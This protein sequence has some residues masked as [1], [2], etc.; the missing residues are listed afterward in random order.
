MLFFWFL[1][2]SFS[3]FTIGSRILAMMSSRSLA[4]FKVIEPLLVELIKRGHDVTFI[5]NYPLGNGITNYTLFDTRYCESRP[6]SVTPFA[7]LHSNSFAYGSMTWMYGY[8]CT[9]DCILKSEQFQQFLKSDRK[10]DLVITEYFMSRLQA[11][12]GHTFS[13]PVVYLSAPFQPPWLSNDIGDPYNPAYVPN[14]L[15]SSASKM[16]FFERLLNT[17][18]LTG[19]MVGYELAYHKKSQQFVHKYYP[20]STPPLRELIKNISLVLVNTHF[21]Y[22]GAL[23]HVPGVVEIGG[24]QISQVQTLPQVISTEIRVHYISNSR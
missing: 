24:I 11:A 10:F 19:M 21:S 22:F 6:L 17:M 18:E 23:P 3:T 14:F 8:F 1:L 13:A 20:P 15:G 5:S 9:F 4:H 12:L 7:E 16:R 2:L